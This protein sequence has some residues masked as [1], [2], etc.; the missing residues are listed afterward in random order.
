MRMQLNKT[1][2]ESEIP[3]RPDD[4]DMFQHVH[5]SRYIDYVL[6]ARYDQMNR[7]YGNPMSEYLEKGLGW[8]VSSCTVN[9]KRALKL[10]ELM[11]VRTNLE[12][13]R[14]NGVRVT[15]SILNKATGKIC[16][17]GHFDYALINIASG[18]SEVIPPWVLEKY[19]LQS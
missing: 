14:T 19:T 17:D 12:E 10:G 9:F 16:C 8:V 5:S 15:F 6:A 7:C 3:V 2:Y 11:I 1:I 18:R 13:L 4:I